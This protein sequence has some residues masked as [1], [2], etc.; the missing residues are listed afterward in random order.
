MRI[1]CPPIASYR[2]ESGPLVAS[3]LARFTKVVHAPNGNARHDFLPIVFTGASE[4]D[5]IGQAERWWSG[6]QDKEEAKV[7]RRETRAPVRR[8]DVSHAEAV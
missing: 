4:A 8:K 2:H 6:E 5:V 7:A 1:P 3:W